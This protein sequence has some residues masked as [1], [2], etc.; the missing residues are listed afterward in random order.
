MG[1]LLVTLILH[2][3]PIKTPYI[4]NLNHFSSLS[5]NIVTKTTTIIQANISYNHKNIN[6]SQQPTKSTNLHNR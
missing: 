5:N 3:Q 6:N 1:Y 2:V 4:L